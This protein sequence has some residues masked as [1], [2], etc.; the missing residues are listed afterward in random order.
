MRAIHVIRSS[1]M[2]QYGDRKSILFANPPS[3]GYIC[4]TMSSVPNTAVLLKRYAGLSTATAIVTIVLKSASY[5]LTGSV[6]FLSD[7]A[8]SLVNLVGAILALAMLSIA[9]RPADDDHAYGHGKAEYFSS[10]VEGTMIFLAGIVIAVTAIRRLASPQPLQQLGL[11]IAVSTIASLANLSTALLLLRAGRRYH[12]IT[13]EA[14]AK[15]LLADVWTTA[16]VIAGIAVVSLTGWQRLDPII[17]LVVTTA[18]IR[19]GIHIVKKS[20]LGLMDTALPAQEQATLTAILESYR[21]EGIDYHAL[22]TR[23]AGPRR[24]ISLHVIVPGAWTVH[25]GHQLLERI[26]ADIR[27]A[28]ANVT[29]LTHLESSEDPSS[30]DDV[31][32]DRT[33]GT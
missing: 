11:G 14:N 9:A 26:E 18:I 24:F 20:I 7:A 2:Y 30:W 4:C 23:Q 29:V 31:A 6:G 22:R 12:S 21:S 33:P 17:A 10:G 15:H 27:S 8:E 1:G 28:L 3:D 32:L 25:E 19:T 16:G 5:F 13:L